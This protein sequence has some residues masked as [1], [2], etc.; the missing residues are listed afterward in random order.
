MRLQE[1]QDE[2]EIDE[3]PQERKL[4]LA[5]KYLEEIEKEEK[6]RLETQDVDQALLGDRVGQERKVVKRLDIDYAPIDSTENFVFVRNVHRLPVTCVA[7]S[8]TGKYL[9]SG[10]KDGRLA[11][12]EFPSGKKMQVAREHKKVKGSEEAPPGHTSGVAC[13]AFSSDGKYLASCDGS[14]IVF[15]WDP[16]KLEIVH[17]FTGH[18]GPVTGVVFRR[19]TYTLYSCSEDRAVKVWDAAEQCYVE[20]LFGHQEKITSIDSLIRERAL[21]AGGRDSTVRVWKIPEES[22]LVFQG[23]AGHSIDIARFL[24]EQHFVSGGEDG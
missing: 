23:N 15:I 11:K 9:I 5:K 1:I 14:N 22:Q 21:T 24:D 16:E 8:P 18:R 2:E 17:R 6:E 3:T 12:Y 20:S 10:G 4:R 7:I 19:S 13:I